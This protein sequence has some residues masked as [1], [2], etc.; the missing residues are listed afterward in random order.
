[1]ELMFNKVVLIESLPKNIFK[2]IE[3]LQHVLNRCL[4]LDVHHKN[5][6]FTEN[7]TNV[8]K[9]YKQKCVIIKSILFASIRN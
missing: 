6:I 8:I 3:F 4:T 2:L 9:F 5:N 7:S 1:M